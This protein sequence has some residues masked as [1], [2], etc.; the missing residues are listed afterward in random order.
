MASRA[1]GHETRDYAQ[2]HMRGSTHLGQTAAPR[3]YRLEDRLN[4]VLTRTHNTR[5]Q[6]EERPATGSTP[7]QQAAQAKPSIR[8]GKESRP[9]RLGHK[10]QGSTPLANPKRWT[11]PRPIPQKRHNL[12]KVSKSQGRARHA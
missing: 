1:L 6:R 12:T 11:R 5:I 8:A 3:R 9:G 10:Q 4:V 7:G 2:Q